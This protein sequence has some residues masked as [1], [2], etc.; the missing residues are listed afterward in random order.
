MGELTALSVAGVFSFEDAFK[1][2]NKR[3]QCMDKAGRLQQDPGAMIAVDVPMPVLEEKVRRC[4]QVYFTNYNSPRQIILGGATREIL[5]LKEEIERE[6]YWTVQLRVSM[7][8]HSPIMK[9]ICD[10]LAEFINTLEIFPPQLPVISNTTQK[11]YPHDPAEIKKII[12]AHLQ[13]PVHWL[14]NVQTLWDDFGI[15]TFVEIGPKDTLGNLIADTIEEATCLKTCYPEIESASCRAALAELYALGHLQP[16]RPPATVAFPC[17]APVTPPAPKALPASPAVPP[18]LGA[19][20]AVVQRE[21]NSFVLETFGKFLK[22]AILAALQRDLDPSFSQGQLDEVL[23]SL[24][25][26]TAAGPAVGTPLPVSGGTAAPAPTH[27]A[28]LG[29]VPAAAP[30]EP[31][32][33]GDYVEEVIQII[34]AAT[35]YERHEIEPQMNI[36]TDLAIRSSRL[37]VIMD[38]AERRFGIKIKVEDFI[39]VR[40]VQEMADRI[41]SVKDRDQNQAPGNGPDAP[42]QPAPEPPGGPLAADSQPA[43]KE[44]QRLI[45]QEIPLKGPVLKPWPSSPGEAVALISLAGQ[46]DL[47]AALA[48][49][50]QK[51]W[52]VSP[53]LLDLAED[54]SL[55][56]A[57][58]LEKAA[59]RLNNLKNCTGCILVL[60]ESAEP[61]LTGIPQVPSLLTGVFS[62]LQDFLR[63]PSKKYCLLVQR[64]LDPA[65]ALAVAAAGV[66]GM[67]L[68]VALE[69]DSVLCRSLTLAQ[70]TDLTGAL[71]RA[72]DQGN[73]LMHLIFHGQEAFGIEARPGFVVSNGGPDVSLASGEVILISG[74]AQGISP[75]LAFA[76]A[77]FNPRLVLLGRSKLDESLVDREFQKTGPVSADRL[78]DWITTQYPDLPEDQREARFHQLL[79]SLHIRETLEQ[80]SR[81]GLTATYHSCDVA[82][83]ESVEKLVA[84]VV[85]RF[86]RISGVIHGAGIL[87]DSLID[88]MSPED[89][90]EVVQVRLPAPMVCAFS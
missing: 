90:S 9:P 47:T 61:S 68:D 76:L 55:P 45:F 43:G 56:A 8:F 81:L 70:E 82:D 41:A 37:P 64:D 32:A 46:T 27:L 49:C 72:L 39:G 84:G 26:Q 13:Q 75:H 53:I 62:L 74:G 86:G 17:L 87:R 29:P 4:Q 6:G 57:S 20:A 10:E 48:E 63:L 19:A 31:F 34:M 38:A 7:A 50:L 80:F 54:G 3:A 71:A 67:L 42:T 69:Y 35:G 21:I 66:A 78:R 12:I 1:I 22:P 28:G 59:S 83:R 88:L 25:G 58:G 14:Q 16:P 65:G 18:G 33:G 85:S 23:A 11:P 79:P 60:D 73:S 77:P 44:L 51:T 5:A 52:Q 24:T 30:A 15:R 89:F 36:R 2:I 40:T